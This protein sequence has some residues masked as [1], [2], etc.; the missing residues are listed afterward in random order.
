MTPAE[1]IAQLNAAKDFVAKRVREDEEREK[2][3]AEW[4]K[5]E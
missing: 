1:L 2:R 4:R 3:V 5:A